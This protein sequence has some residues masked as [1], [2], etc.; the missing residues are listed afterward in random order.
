MWRK[1]WIKKDKHNNKDFID[2]I[3]SILSY[4]G[5]L[6]EFDIDKA[7]VDCHV[8]FTVDNCLFK[9]STDKFLGHDSLIGC[10]WI[11]NV[12]KRIN[13]DPWGTFVEELDVSLEALI[14]HGSCISPCFILGVSVLMLL[15]SDGECSNEK[16]EE[17]VQNK[18][19]HI[20]TKKKI[21]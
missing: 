5:K 12:V 3:W 7:I 19:V 8:F 15:K 9:L 1:Y 10:G 16:Q 13:I 18:F 14:W 21:L 6:F 2:F 20:W 11:R 4:F 17:G